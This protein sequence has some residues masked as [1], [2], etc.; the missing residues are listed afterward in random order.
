MMITQTLELAKFREAL[1]SLFPMRKA[2]IMNLLDA[3][4]S[5]GHQCHSIVQLSNS[6]CYER[7]YSSITDA[8]ADGLPHAN[9]DQIMK[10]VFK[11]AT[12]NQDGQIARFIVDCTPNPRPHA[13]KLADRTITHFPNPAPG[14]KPI[15][16]GH[17]Y[18][19]LGLLPNNSA[20]E[21]KHWMIP[22]SAGR[23]SSDQ[24]GNEF[25]M[26]QIS[27]CI[28]ILGLTD[29][30]SISIA[31]S[32]YG[33]ENC[34]IT[35]SQQDNLIHIF[36]L[37]S[38]R[39]LFFA[40]ENQSQHGNKRG[41]KK[42]FGIKMSLNDINL[43]PTPDEQAE[44]NW[45]SRKGKECRVVIQCWK[46]ML[47]RGSRQ[48]RSSRYPMHLVKICIIDQQGN[49]VFKHPLWLAIFGKRREEISI[50][51]CYKNYAGRYDI[52]HFLRFGKRKLL[53]DTY[54]TPDVE[55]EECWWK[56]CILAYAQLYFARTLVPLLPEPWERFLPEYQSNF[57]TKQNVANAAQAQRGFYKIL[58][59][60]GTPAPSPV[61]RGNP[62]GRMKGEMMPKRVNNDII[63][64]KGRR[65][66]ST[67]GIIWGFEN[68]P[69]D[70]NPEKIDG[71]IKLVRAVLD[72][73][74]LSPTKFA[75]I[76]IDSS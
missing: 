38:K 43:H 72:K 5:N 18:S 61:Q 22:L 27:D 6:D 31:D 73:L 65:L 33:T 59:E 66:K 23:V 25:G 63:F 35:A 50:V 39:N 4:T 11:Q 71:L 2:A 56:L 52:E 67:K 1:Y 13:N 34:R 16:V 47:I 3:L 12:T 49:M 57:A 10:L 64:K 14:N 75:K 17:Q 26:Q 9:W 37:N 24:K 58:N 62:C 21:K 55:H 40:P 54:Q 60:I 48:F 30:L 28:K 29:Q 19:L 68:L 70:S 51:Q 15:C 45:T 41:R 74:Q 69:I 42:E 76:L 46:N 44:T 7:Q 53:M 8:I 32:L 20:D 36:R